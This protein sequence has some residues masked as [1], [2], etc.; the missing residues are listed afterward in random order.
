MKRKIQCSIIILILVSLA[1]PAFASEYTPLKSPNMRS[2]RVNEA[3]G[4]VAHYIGGQLEQ[5]DTVIFTLPDD[6]FW[7]K[8][9]LNAE[10]PAAQAAMQTDAEWGTASLLKPSVMRYGTD[11]NYIIVPESYSGNTNGLFNGGTPTLE[12][13]TLNDEEIMVKVIGTPG[14]LDDSYMILYSNRV[15]AA[16]GYNGEVSIDIDSPERALIPNTAKPSADKPASSPPQ[17]VNSSPEKTVDD[18]KEI[19]SE[20]PTLIKLRTGQ[21]VMQIDGKDVPIE[22]AP[23]INNERMYAPLRVLAEALGIDKSAISWD[24]ASQQIILKE[25]NKEVKINLVNNTILINDRL[26]YTMD[27]P[28]EIQVSGYAMIPVRYMAMALDAAVTW[29]ADE[30]SVLISK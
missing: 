20:S 11:Y 21:K 9:E 13:T 19:K 6:F 17:T 29:N 2:G 7:T 24:T 18:S 30:K 10:K 23:Y 16:D 14:I 22:V 4:I 25:E 26:S 15:Y 3:G 12:V 27:T 8:A 5:G 1:N 28:I